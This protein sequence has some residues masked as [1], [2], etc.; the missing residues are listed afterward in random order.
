M[1]RN[2]LSALRRTT[3][4][5]SRS[6]FLIH[7]P[8]S[9]RISSSGGL[10]E[11]PAVFVRRVGDA[12]DDVLR[13]LEP[14]RRDDLD[15]NRE[16]DIANRV[17]DRNALL[18]AVL[19]SRLDD[20]DVDITVLRHL[21]RRGRPEQNDPVRLRHGQHAADDFVQYQFIDAHSFLMI[22]Q[23]RAEF[24]SAGAVEQLTKAHS[25]NADFTGAMWR[26]P[27]YRP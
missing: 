24:D 4:L 1:S 27:A 25:E 26:L 15:V 2:S 9:S 12:A 11:D 19:R 5:K 21:A 17:G 18:M 23:E 10:I 20:Q 13:C 22:D 14:F 8:T 3:V 6:A 16:A 7:S